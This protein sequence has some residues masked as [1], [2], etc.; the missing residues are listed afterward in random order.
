MSSY[1]TGSDA[2]KVEPGALPPSAF[3]SAKTPAP[4]I[5]T[6]NPTYVLLNNTGSFNFIMNVVSESVG[7]TLSHTHGNW[8][9]GI[10]IKGLGQGPVRLD[11]SPVAWSGSGGFTGASNLSAGDVTFVYRG[12]L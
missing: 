10:V 4:S 12:G 11:I 5:V 8:T 9:Q 7:S 2:T 1:I 3:G 6:K